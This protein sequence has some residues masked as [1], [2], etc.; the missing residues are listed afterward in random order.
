MSISEAISVITT[1]VSRYNGQIMRRQLA[2]DVMK[3][4]PGSGNYSRKLGTMK[5]G[6]GLLLGKSMLS[7]TE[8]GQ[9][10]VLTKDPRV[11]ARA[12]A[13]AFLRYALFQRLFNR[14][15]NK[16]PDD[17]AL[18]GMIGEITKQ[19]RIEVVKKLPE[20]RKLYADGLQY[21][22]GMNA[23]DVGADSGEQAQIVEPPSEPSGGA[24][25]SQ[26]M[27]KEPVKEGF[28]EIKMGNVRIFLRPELEDVSVAEGLL[29]VMRDRLERKSPKP[30]GSTN[31]NG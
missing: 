18:M 31:V 6:Y 21:L 9:R 5:D 29:K 23:V 13:D 25:L 27:V 28:E 30:K 16:L 19:E 12:K 20:I 11:S 10:M 1:V 22:K 15:G 24:M 8:L 7:A 26:V 2:T 4:A 3:V 14:T 17:E